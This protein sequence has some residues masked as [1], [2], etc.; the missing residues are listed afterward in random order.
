MKIIEFEFENWYAFC[1]RFNWL[2]LIVATIVVIIASLI[3]L[4]HKNSYNSIATSD[5]IA[6]LNDKIKYTAMI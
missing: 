6:I 4:Y 2:A 5:G 3:I 1:L